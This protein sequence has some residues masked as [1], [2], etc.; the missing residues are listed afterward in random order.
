[1]Q[2]QN[3]LNIVRDTGSEL[4]PVISV[5]KFRE[6]RCPYCNKLL[7][8]AKLEKGSRIQIPCKRNKCKRFIK[9]EVL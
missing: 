3:K 6:W 2:Q 4:P 1:M 5:N 9:F 7:F 8:K